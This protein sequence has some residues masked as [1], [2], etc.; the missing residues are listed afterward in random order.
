MLPSPQNILHPNYTSLH[1]RHPRRLSRLSDALSVPPSPHCLSRPRAACSAAAGARRRRWSTGGGRGCRVAG[2]CAEDR[3]RG[4]EAIGDRQEGEPLGK[5]NVPPRRRQEDGVPSPHVA[6]A[7][8]AR[9]GGRML[10]RRRTTRD[11]LH[12]LCELRFL[13]SFCSLHYTVGLLS[14]ESNCQS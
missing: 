3:R 7:H 4:R 5:G 2:R 14:W 9:G 8:A 1:P 12:V 10:R 13:P 11:A 6:A